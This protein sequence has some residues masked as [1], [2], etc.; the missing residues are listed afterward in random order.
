M[1]EIIFKLTFFSKL[2]SGLDG[3]APESLHGLLIL[4]IACVVL[5]LYYYSLEVAQKD[6]ICDVVHVLLILLVEREDQ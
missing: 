2:N 5:N 6:C 1:S 3:R 4:F